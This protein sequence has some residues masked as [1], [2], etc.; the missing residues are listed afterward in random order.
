VRKLLALAVIGV[1]ALALI[2]APAASAKGGDD[3]EVIKRGGCTGASTW[4]LKLKFD[5]GRIETEFEVDQNR[6]GKRW[7]VVLRQDGVLRFRRIRTTRPPSG[8]FEIERHLRNTRGKDRI[9]ARARALGSGEV[10]RGVATI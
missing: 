4:K 2:V 8:S 9:V 10:C 6:I 1:A 5:D 3:R 7:R